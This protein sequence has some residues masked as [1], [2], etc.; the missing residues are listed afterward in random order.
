[1]E[2]KSHVGM[3]NCWICGEGAEIMLDMRL[4][5]TLSRNMGSRPDIC[6]SS[7][8]SQANDNDAIWLISVKDGEEPI[9]G[10]IF[11]PYRTGAM[12]LIKKEALRR[13]FSQTLTEDVQDRMIDMV[14]RNIYFFLEDMAWDAFGL[15]REVAND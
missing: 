8:E 15:P 3:L 9:D 13:I 6:C 7:C 1:M 10:E 14:D 12:C 4:R 5:N 2:E 11:N